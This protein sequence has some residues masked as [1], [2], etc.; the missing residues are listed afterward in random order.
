MDGKHWVSRLH[1]SSRDLEER[2]FIS[3][4]TK[5]R[6]PFMNI[7]LVTAVYHSDCKL[8]ITRDHHETL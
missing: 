2:D 1:V 8:H 6:Y 3:L 7:T 4:G 5:F